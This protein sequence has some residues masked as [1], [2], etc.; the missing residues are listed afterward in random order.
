MTQ[1]SLWYKDTIFYELSIRAFCDS[2]ADGIGDFR[3]AT[4]KLEYLRDLGVTCIW[5]LPFYPS[6]LKDDGYDIAD[7]YGVHADYGTVDD[8]RAFIVAAHER[9]IRVIADLV[10]NH[11][12]DQHPWFRE[13][14]AASTSAKRD[15]YVWS[16]TPE[17]YQGVRVIFR[18]FETSN[19]T[20]HPEAH[21]Y[22]WHRFYRHQPDLN[23][24]NPR[25]RQ[26]VLQIA[27]FWL[28]LG[29]DG[30][31]CDAV[32]HLFEREGTSCE[33]L[34]ET[35]AYFKELRRDLERTHPECVLLGEANQW[36]RETAIY[37][38]DGDE[39]HMTFHFPLVTRMF[40]ALAR[41][42]SAPIVDI[43]AQTP[44]I[45]ANCQWA[46]FLRNHDETTM[47]RVSEDDRAVLYHTYATTP[48][49]RLN[50]GIRRRLAPLVGHDLR[51]LKLLYSLIF[52]LPGSPVLYY[53]D[54]IGMGDDVSRA[55]RGGLRTPMQWDATRNAG[56]STADPAQLYA[57]V[58]CDP[59]ASYQHMNV[60]TQ[61]QDRQSLVSWL[62]NII[63]V[64][65]RL[66]VFAHGALELLTP[67]NPHVFAYLRTWRDTKVLV[68]SNLSHQKQEV[69]LPLQQFTGIAPLDICAEHLLSQ[70]GTL[71]Y[72][73]TLN[74]YEFRWLQLQN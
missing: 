58:I 51:K 3:G 44:T 54:D 28:D 5:L 56:F 12:S 73:L 69:A 60:E 25:V 23:Y 4:Q 68:V 72:A 24:D 35:H 2:N 40:L 29:M 46:V 11:T 13:A 30:F 8:C 71:P 14:C 42:S 67:A 65:K 21:A 41:E 26:E 66:S 50:N 74:P 7:Y 61:R 64:R 49:M 55:D 32:P 38:G 9:G 47:S 36:P 39:F 6:P 45:P 17:K 19:W 31:R 34:P 18:D 1:P 10:L 52:S 33:G 16:D 27:R 57:P 62:K 48:Q 43:L 15:Y 53:G 59:P 37:F 70:I 20:W 63:A 22:Y